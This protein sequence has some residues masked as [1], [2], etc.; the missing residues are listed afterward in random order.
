MNDSVS[1]IND[2][3]RQIVNSLSLPSFSDSAVAS[4]MD[5]RWEML[6][7]TESDLLS[8]AEW[9]QEQRHLH[10]SCFH[11]FKM[12]GKFLAISVNDYEIATAAFFYSVIGLE[13]SLR[14]HYSEKRHSPDVDAS[15]S[16]LIQKAVN[17]GVISDKILSGSTPSLQFFKRSDSR[18]KDAFQKQLYCEQL[19]TLIPR[20]RN[21][22][23]HGEYIVFEDAVELSVHLRQFADALVTTKS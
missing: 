20:L 6:D 1:Q 14:M 23:L 16:E 4:K 17:E 10:D 2:P 9:M 11:F 12:A 18:F 3:V 19:T 8:A 13:R 22:Y 7:V 15:L 21:S 5:K